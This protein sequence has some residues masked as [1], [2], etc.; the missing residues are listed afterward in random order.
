MA[1]G[2]APSKNL[3][4]TLRPSCRDLPDEVEADVEP[5]SQWYGQLIEGV[6]FAVDQY[7][8]HPPAGQ[9]VELFRAL[10]H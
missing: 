6:L 7:P 10:T 8:D 9:G 2:G 1:N 4:P 5:V 3:A